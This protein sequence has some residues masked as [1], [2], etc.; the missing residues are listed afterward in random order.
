MRSWVASKISPLEPAETY[1]LKGSVSLGEVPLGVVDG[2]ISLAST[3]ISDDS[4]RF[5]VN[6][7]PD[8]ISRIR[9][10]PG[11]TP[12]YVRPLASL[13]IAQA[14]PLF[15]ELDLSDDLA[16]A[17]AAEVREG[18]LDLL[19]AALADGFPIAPPAG[20]VASITIGP[21]QYPSISDAF[22]FEIPAVS[23]NKVKQFDPVVVSGKDYSTRRSVDDDAK[24]GELFERGR[25][26]RP[27]RGFRKSYRESF[28][29]G[30]VSRQTLTIWDLLWPLLQRPLDIEGGT[31]D[32]P[33]EIYG[34]QVEGIKRLMGS[35]SFLLADEMGTGKT[36]MASVALR[37]LFHQ[38]KVKRALVLCPKS[39]LGV[40]DHHLREWA[41]SLSVTVV[42]GPAAVRA[43]DWRCPA[44]VYVATY[45]TLRNDSETHKHE[46][47]S[48]LEK[49]IGDGTFD[50]I[51]ADE[52][53]A[54]KNSTAGRAK[55]V[56]RLSENTA[57]RWALTG[58]PV[59]NSL[60]DLRSI[61]LF[62]KPRLFPK[63]GVLM[64][65]DARRKIEPYFLR[66]RKSDVFPELP[67]KLK[68]D[69]WLELDSEQQAE[70]NS[71]LSEGK[72][73]FTSGKK[74]FTRLHV[75]ALLQ[76]LKEICNFATHSR[77]SPKSDALLDHIEEIVAN[78]KKLLVFSQYKEHG[79]ER[80]EPILRQFGV[81]KVTGGSSDKA[82]KA[83]VDQFQND[84][85]RRVFLATV[86][87]MS[88]GVTLTAASFVVHFDHWWNPATGW[89]A[90]D[91]AHRKGQK[92]TV[93]VYS[94]WMRGTIE[95]R[96][97]QILQRKGLLHD[98]VIDS[99][100]AKD[101]EQPF[102]M[103]DLLEILELNR[104]SVRM[105][106][107]ERNADDPWNLLTIRDRFSSLA[108]AEFERAVM[109]VFRD[110]L[111]FSNA[112]VVGRAGDGGIDVEATKM[113]LGKLERVV[114]QCKRM[115][116]VGPGVARELLGVLAADERLT[117]GFLVTSGV[118][119]RACREFCDKQKSLRGIDGLQLAKW[120]RE[121][122]LRIAGVT[123]ENS[124]G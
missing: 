43:V 103:N 117:G 88:E 29:H 44:H 59:Q 63:D 35:K 69:E 89:Q 46:R 123:S 54:I 64:P 15:I 70:Y 58:T 87:S 39:V 115:S 79:T 30:L 78:D 116:S 26:D 14:Q 51:V 71:V 34:F 17:T 120:I 109:M 61:F 95:E 5:R 8:F 110:A 53:H 114:I 10:V 108:P 122:K 12:D 7:T 22:P 49:A 36:V 48:L 62:V 20:E 37:L 42:N 52:A 97:R 3:S 92:E 86:K 6:W 38:G 85:T 19:P 56:L 4:A 25:D 45:D 73:E 121:K 68:S 1:H 16:R 13:H 32:F 27:T 113:S 82:R 60:D 99:L 91:R 100:S 2:P 67:P 102:T 93:N 106:D 107:W 24:Q 21:F 98:E 50:A 76:R 74:E 55:A 40:W 23:D 83:A 18:L 75:F 118:L 80:L 11:T 84:P 105:P 81:I 47:Q 104:G 28:E 41:S 66:R 90:E 101:L 33:N 119:T 9:E 124:I 96:I 57:Y 65:E 77:T 72:A 111:G 31:L 112:R 94:Y